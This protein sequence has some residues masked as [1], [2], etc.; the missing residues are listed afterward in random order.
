MTASGE[1]I[2]S[3]GRR[4]GSWLPL[5]LAV[6]VLAVVFVLVA[7]RS[8]PASTALIIVP[9]SEWSVQQDPAAAEATFTR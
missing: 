6:V 5:V 4:A 3:V 7:L 9:R 1:E 8:H 2:L